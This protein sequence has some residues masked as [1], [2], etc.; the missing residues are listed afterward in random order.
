MLK[1]NII[2]ATANRL[3]LTEK[4]SLSGYWQLI[5]GS[6]NRLDSNNAMKMSAHNSTFC[7]TV[8]SHDKKKTT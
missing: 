1:T 7:V 5:T 4:G 2:Q 8:K 6:C 3:A